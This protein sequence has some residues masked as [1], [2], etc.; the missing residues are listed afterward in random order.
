MTRP[1]PSVT[2]VVDTS[3]SMSEYELDQAL[4][5]I[6]AIIAT[7]VPGDSV[8]VLSVDADVHTDQH[9][10]NTN[11]ITLEGAGGT[12]MATG[13][14]TAADTKPDAIVVVTDGF[15]PWPPTR[16]RGARCVIAA[17][18]DD[19]CIDRVPDWIQAIDMSERFD[20]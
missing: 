17:L 19:H 6:S 18:T 5:E 10:Y 2:V 8:R 9:I 13:I 15:T 4:T 16:P 20:A 11:Q 12:N 1:V 7:V 14:E 3:G